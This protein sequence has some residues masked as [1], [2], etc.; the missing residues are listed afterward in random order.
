M[1]LVIFKVMMLDDLGL[2]STL[3]HVY[4]LGILRVASATGC[5]HLLAHAR[6][7]PQEPKCSQGPWREGADGWDVGK[8]KRQE[9]DWSEPLVDRSDLVQQ[10]VEAPGHR[11][12]RAEIDNS[13][14]QR[15][16][17]RKAT[18]SL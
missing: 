10:L 9:A 7:R 18:P 14:H 3:K 2:S 5:R 15:E 1:T 8:K 4:L 13:K 16:R 11:R 12:R 17:M 6:L